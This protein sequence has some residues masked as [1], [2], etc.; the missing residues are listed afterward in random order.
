MSLPW[1]GGDTSPAQPPVCPDTPG[2]QNQTALTR[3]GGAWT[4]PPLLE[5]NAVAGRCGGRGK[6]SH[7][8]TQHSGTGGTA[9]VREV[10]PV[11]V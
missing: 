7:H 4:S 10:I 9:S 2:S 8:R 1:I 11:T 3:T 5:A 6:Y